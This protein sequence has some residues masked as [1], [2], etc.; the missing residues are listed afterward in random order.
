MKQIWAVFKKE[1]VDHWRDRRSVMNNLGMLALMGPLMF[2]PMFYSIKDQMNKS[3]TLKLAVLGAERA[4]ALINY[5]HSHQIQTETAPA[6]YENKIRDGKLDVVLS[7]PEKFPVSFSK[8]ESAKLEL[9]LDDTQPNS[10]SVIGKVKNILENYSRQMGELRLLARG[11]DPGVMNVVKVENVDLAPPQQSDSFL[12][13]LAVGYGLLAAFVGAMAMSLDMSA[14]ERERGSLEPLL[15]NPISP[16]KLLSG[17]WLAASL[18]SIAAVIIT[19]SSYLLTLNIFPF[20]TL[21][22]SIRFGFVEFLLA[23]LIVI[24]TSFLFA[25]LLSLSGLFAKTF[26]EAQ[27]T[28]SLMIFF[29]MLPAIILLFKPMKSSIDTMAIPLLSQNLLLADLIRGEKINFLFAVIAA[30]VTLALGFVCISMAAKIIQR[31]KIIFGR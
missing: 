7:I 31:E 8:G 5:L 20:H 14:G 2:G 24:P 1:I 30:C 27:I 28:A 15:V 13:K 18:L 26:K 10:K 29:V 25:G 16:Q 3:D 21:G 19:F 11:I 6:D 12:L 22:M 23:C 17:K 9:I 4:P